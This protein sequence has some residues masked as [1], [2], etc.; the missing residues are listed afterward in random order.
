MSLVIRPME[1][2]D[3]RPLG[4]ALA[5]L[6]LFTAYKLD[7]AALESRFTKALE[8]GEGLVAA[9]LDGAL[10]GVCW[11]I[12]RG[13]F[14]TGAY[15]RT[16]AVKEGLQGKGIG[17]KLLEAYES[18]SGAPPGGFFLL[19]SDFNEGAHR[20]YSR[21]G[22]REVGRLPDFAAKGVTERVFWKPRT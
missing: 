10:V 14:G 7:A 6:P 17:Q 1:K 4:E 13:A 16:L 12:A 2:S 15:L 9:E 8:R 19:A 11:F 21:Y 3:A 20:F 18:G 22:Y 5:S